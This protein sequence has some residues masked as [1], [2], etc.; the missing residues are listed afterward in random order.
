MG[1]NPINPQVSLQKQQAAS[2]LKNNPEIAEN[3]LDEAQKKELEQKK[4]PIEKHKE[5]KEPTEN[6]KEDQTGKFKEDQTDKKPPKAPSIENTLNRPEL[7]A[8]VK[9]KD[10]VVSEIEKLKTELKDI[11]GIRETAL[12]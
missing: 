5:K 9:E 7:L 1:G 2:K 12:K 3:N 8:L 4:E 11:N 10:R 6:F